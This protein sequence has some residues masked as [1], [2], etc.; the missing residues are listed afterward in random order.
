MFEK[1]APFL[2][3]EET[4]KIR[5]ARI[6]VVGAGAL[7]QS[8]VPVLV[9]GGAEHLTLVD[10]DAVSVSDFN[11]QLYADI[12]TLGKSKTDVLCER[13]GEI[14]PRLKIKNYNDFFQR[15]NSGEILKEAD[16]VLDC[17]DNIPSRL[18]LEEAAEKREI[19]LVHAA[20]E[21]WFGQIGTVFPGDR[22][23]S[24]LFARQ[25]EQ[26]DTAVMPAVTAAAAF[27]A[28]EALRI[29]AGK[30]ALLRGKL[31][32][33][34]MLRGETEKILITGNHAI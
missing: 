23:L 5:R 31:L 30:T 9:R 3:R 8:V 19:P 32:C 26:T 27:Q 18:C 21:G 34:D 16:L 2:T 25:K 7:G 10:G 6:V 33:I 12:L 22:T 24:F 13:M 11:R 14:S 29:A 20:V 17:V 1:N 4:E 15:E 28:A